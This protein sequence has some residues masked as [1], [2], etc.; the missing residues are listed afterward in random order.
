MMPDA[1]SPVK[2]VCEWTAAGFEIMPGLE[3]RVYAATDRL[4]AELQTNYAAK[5][6]QTVQAQI[7]SWQPLAGCGILRRNYEAV[8]Q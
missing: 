3:F 8:D 5:G 6:E 1:I 4:K 7:E 2:V